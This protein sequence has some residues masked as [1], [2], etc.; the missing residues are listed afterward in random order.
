MFVVCGAF[1]PPIHGMAAVNMMI[2][3]LASER[4]DSVFK[5]DLAPNGLNRGLAAR[6]LKLIKLSLAMFRMAG[7]VLRYRRG[8]LYVGLSGGLG[9]LVELPVIALARLAGWRIALHHHSF[10]Y[11]EHPS[12]VS[13]ILFRIAGCS[14]L[15]IAL[16]TRM[17]ILLNKV[18][19]EKLQVKVLSNAALFSN[20]KQPEIRD[21]IKT[22][23]FMS[24]ISFEKGIA[25]F[26]AT[27]EKLSN[28]GVD[29]F[30]KI[31]GPFV[32][33]DVKKYTLNEIERLGC[34]EYIG[35][36]YGDAKNLFYRNIDLL[37]FPTRYRNEAEPLTI[38]ESLS[39]AVP[40]VA[41]G[42]GCIPDISSTVSGVHMVPV[43][44][45][46]SEIAANLIKEWMQDG[47]YSEI[48]TAAFNG[49]SSVTYVWQNRLN[50]LMDEL[51]NEKKNHD[52]T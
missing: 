17:Q 9:Q 47:N 33:E 22:I 43:E 2:F 32:D 11:L 34:V 6:S 13:R 45:L 51:L 48:S 38:F 37:L 19:G 7:L 39:H 5:L 20:L 4:H 50:D 25:E 10:A 1:P 3:D 29:I 52:F 27:I 26:F 41:T 14:V 8:C 46:F 16:C 28:S 18:Y 49:Y 44:S 35:P 42:R 15:H 21:R 12:L 40:V 30:A 31:A 23:G 36:V 24:N